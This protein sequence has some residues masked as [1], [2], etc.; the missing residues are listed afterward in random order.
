MRPSEIFRGARQILEGG[1]WTQGALRDKGP[2]PDPCKMAGPPQEGESFCIHG[3]LSLATSENNA[4][5]YSMPMDVYIILEKTIK[6]QYPDFLFS[7]FANWNDTYKR[8]EAEVITILHKAELTA[9][10]KE[11]GV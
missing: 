1:H 9:E 4:C 7:T 8:T 10:D 3:A 5:S 6:E 11:L 2:R